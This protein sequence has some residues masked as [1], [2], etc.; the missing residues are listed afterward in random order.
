MPELARRIVAIALLGATLAPPVCVHGV[1]PETTHADEQMASL[2]ADRPEI[3]PHL[4]RRDALR[5]W[6]ADRFRDQRPRLEWSDDTPVSG[7]YAEFDARDPERLVLRVDDEL[8]GIDQLALL[9]FEMNNARRDSVFACIFERAVDGEL[10]RE[11]FAW[12]ML[13]QESH[14]LA[15]AQG[16]LDEHFEPLGD[17]ERAAA[18]VYQRLRRAP[19]DARALRQRNLD[20]GG[21]LLDHFRSL[22]EDYVLPERTARGED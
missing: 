21:D 12:A 22:Y 3:R 17:D 13:E 18:R 16:V 2:L 9:V 11:E 5:Q 20:A 14:A 7:R 15:A 4:A 6:M 1:Q 10:D 19:V 8:S